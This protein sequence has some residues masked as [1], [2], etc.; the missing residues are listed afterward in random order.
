[1]VPVDRTHLCQETC[2]CCIA[3]FSLGKL[4]LFAEPVLVCRAF[5]V[6]TASP[7][8]QA[9]CLFARPFPSSLED[10]CLFALYAEPLSLW[11]PVP[12]RSLSLPAASVVTSRALPVCITYR[13]P[14]G[15]PL[16]A[17]PC[18]SV[19]PV[20]NSLFAEVVRRL[21]ACYCP[22]SSALFQEHRH[23]RQARSQFA[24]PLCHRLWYLSWFAGTC[25]P[26]ATCVPN[27]RHSL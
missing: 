23:R 2:A 20:S 17:D 24:K 3:S 13:C 6:Y 14:R 19:P 7:F 1:M 12:I 15:L 21:K 22:Q 4:S 10:L 11:E 27:E 18:L 25:V 26:I 8:L 9:Q 16:T 5:S